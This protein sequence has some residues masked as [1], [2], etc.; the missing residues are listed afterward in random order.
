MRTRV[1]IQSRLSSTR[2]PGKALLDLAGMPLIELVARRLS[3]S[4]HEVVVATSDDHYDDHI[5]DTLTARGIPAMRGPLDDVLARFVQAT[6]DL[7]DDDRVVRMTGDNPFADADLIDELAAALEASSHTYGRV[8]IDQTPEGLGC[9][10]FTVAM[11][12]Q[13]DRAATLPYDREHVTPWIRRHHSELLFA[14]AANPPDLLAYRSTVDCLDDYDRARRAFDQVADPVAIPWTELMARLGTQG[15]DT[16]APIPREGPIEALRSR[17][18]LAAPTDDAITATAWRGELVDA[19][20]RGVTH[21][22]LDASGPS[23]RH[24]SVLRG[25]IDP[26]LR[27]RVGVVVDGLPAGETSPTLIERVFAVLGERR[28]GALVVRGIPDG[29]VWQHLI[30][31]REAGTT[32]GIGIGISASEELDDAIGLEPDWVIID[33]R[34]SLQAWA[35]KAHQLVALRGR[36]TVV[37]VR[38][39]DAGLLDTDWVSTVIVPRWA[40]D[41]PSRA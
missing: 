12:R 4:G 28:V 37:A 30:G 21:A 26:L 27:G 6:D 29:A 40:P 1:V 17:I 41:Q 24:G 3:R 38:S 15:P 11:L 9:E 22:V 18:V 25:A 39:D 32:R 36:G 19:V 33:P 13:A 2:L 35:E 7:A 31:Q 8:D 5:I 14:P 23:L 20:R 16:W 10:V 34:G